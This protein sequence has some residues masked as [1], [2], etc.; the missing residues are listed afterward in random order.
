MKTV[1]WGF[2]DVFFPEKPGDLLF[3]LGFRQSVHGDFAQERQGDFPVL[4]NADGL[5]QVIRPEY[6]DLEKVLGPDLVFLDV[7][8][9]G[10]QGDGQK[11][12]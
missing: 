9:L 8:I 7:L 10:N 4:G 2:C 11:H 1:T 12:R 3:D 6:A 5:A